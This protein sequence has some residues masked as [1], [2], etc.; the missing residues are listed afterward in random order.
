MAIEQ[1]YAKAYS[2]AFNGGKSH[3]IQNLAS[4]LKDE[5]LRSVIASP[6][7][8]RDDKLKL[9]LSLLDDLG[10]AAKRGGAN[11][12]DKENKEDEQTKLINFLSLLALNGR[13]NLLPKIYQEVRKLELLES[14]T[15]EL[16]VFSNHDPRNDP[17]NTK[18]LEEIRGMLAKE[19]GVKLVLAYEYENVEGIRLYVDTFGVEVSFMRE[20]FLQA[21]K[22]FILE[23]F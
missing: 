21:M 18:L 1:T 15:H 4:L 20:N 11:K 23:V 14:N 5:R 22:K 16:T 7:I 6:L 2:A 3:L 10:G 8:K 17:A 12:K 19:L 13:L 9:M